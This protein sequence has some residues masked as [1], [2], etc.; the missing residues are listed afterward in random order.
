[1]KHVMVSGATGKFCGWPANN[2]L[3]SWDDGR[4]ILVGFSSGAYVEQPGHNLEGGSDAA[5]GVA[6]RLARSLD[7]GRTWTAEDPTN[8][9]GDGGLP[10][11]SPGGFE[12][13]APGSALRVV[14]VGYHGSHDPV[15]SFYVSED[16]GRRWRGPYRFGALMDDQNLRGMDLTARTRY[17]ATGPRSCMLFMSAR[18]TRSTPGQI[19]TDKSFVVETT[20]GGRSF[21]FVAWIVP[22]DDPHRAVM[23][24]V[25]RLEDGALVVALRRRNI[26][27]ADMP[28]WLDCY[29]SGDN[30]RS[31]AFLSRV[32]ET[33]LENGNPPAL[34]ALKDGRVACAYGDRSRGKLFARVS[35]DGARSWGSEIVLRDDFEP[36]KFGDHDFGYPQLTTNHTGDLVALYYWAT[37]QEPHQ[38]IAGTVWKP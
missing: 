6:S 29:A 17:L 15:G 25:G 30:G 19:A 33:G 16:R 3:W 1:M 22:L 38:H 20:D 14:G 12:F 32:G 2:G 9:V 37:A 23:P 8:F 24:A 36:D 26:Q 11:H 31:W 10:T 13:Q 35:A 4:E 34:T 7:G 5:P 18:P 27:D 28:C 21:R